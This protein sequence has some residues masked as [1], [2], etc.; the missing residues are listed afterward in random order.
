MPSETRVRRRSRGRT[1]LK[2]GI[3]RGPGGKP[4][5]FEPGPGMAMMQREELLEDWRLCREKAQPV[6]IEPLP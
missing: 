2:L 3:I 6:N 1:P 4:P 5:G